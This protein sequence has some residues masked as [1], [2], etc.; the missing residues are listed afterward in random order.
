MDENCIQLTKG[1]SRDHRPD[2]NHAVLNLIVENQASIPLYMKAASG[3]KNDKEGFQEIIKSHLNSFK[4]AQDNPYFIM[5]AAGYT[6]ANLSYFHEQQCY[7]VSRGPGQI[8]EA[9]ELIQEIDINQMIDLPKGYKG[10]W[11]DSNYG[12]VSQQWLMSVFES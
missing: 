9:R 6:Q 8:K 3:N 2:L 1:Y 7:L 4:S 12:D 10:Y 11:H 5:D